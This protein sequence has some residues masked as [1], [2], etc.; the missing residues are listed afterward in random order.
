MLRLSERLNLLGS[1][2]QGTEREESISIA[3]S[4]RSYLQKVLNT[5]VGS[6]L[7]SPQMG[8][9]KIDVSAGL[10]NEYDQEQLLKQ[11]RL[12]LLRFD[13]R[14]ANLTAQLTNNHNVTVLLSFQ[15]SFTTQSKLAISMLGK[16]QSDSTFELEL[17]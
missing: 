3:T 14:I 1:Q 10:A 6:V 9:E 5:R 12:V 15:L 17:Q 4:M 2:G 7:C 13:P 11:I 8:L 16:L